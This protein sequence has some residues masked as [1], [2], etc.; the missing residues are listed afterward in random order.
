MDL[1]TQQSNLFGAYFEISQASVSKADLATLDV[2]LDM[3]RS[4]LGGPT[5]E[6]II[7]FAGPLS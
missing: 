4:T 5:D 6:L 1:A 3:Q 7:L 2:K